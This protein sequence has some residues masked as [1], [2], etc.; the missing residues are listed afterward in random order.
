M[1]RDLHE[2]EEGLKKR[3][4]DLNHKYTLKA[5]KFKERKIDL[6]MKEL[7]VAKKSPGVMAPRGSVLA[8]KEL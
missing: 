7:A 1:K 2:K 6:D 5:D 3:E 8:P 4:A